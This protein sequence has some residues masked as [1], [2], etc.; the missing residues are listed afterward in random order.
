MVHSIRLGV[1]TV[2]LTVFPIWPGAHAAC[3]YPSGQIAPNDIPCR[4]D[5][6]HAACCAPGYACLSNG[7]CQATGLEQGGPD[8]SEFV[9]GACTD[10]SWRNSNCPLFCIEE[11]VDFLPGGNGIA[12][13]D[14]D[15]GDD[16]Y[17]CINVRSSGQATC[18]D[19]AKVLFFPGA[20]GCDTIDR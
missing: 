13:C 15:T 18:Q 4:D 5:T 1:L 6:P 9:R 2:V 19:R 14:N 16:T 12:K 8:A 10:Q 20:L 3:Y 7:I 11:G 17:Y